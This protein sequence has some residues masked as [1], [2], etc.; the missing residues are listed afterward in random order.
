MSAQDG[1]RRRAY[2]GRVLTPV[3]AG[4]ARVPELRFLEDGVVIVGPSG[5]IESVEPA[6]PN[7][8]RPALDLHPHLI[9][10][11]FADAHVHYPQTRVVGAATGG[12]LDWLERTVF[13]EEMRFG[14]A[15]Y[16]GEVA[17]EFFG[18]LR[19]AGTTCAGIYA[20][21]SPVSAAVAM[22]RA[23]A[24]GMLAQVGLVLMDRG[25]PEGLLVPRERALADQ[26][27]LL[28]A[29]GG[30]DVRPAVTPRFALSC[31]RELLRDAGAF[32][33]ER[34]LFVQTHLSENEGEIAATRA[35]F[36]EA[37]DYFGVYEEAGLAGERSL[38]AHAIHLSPRE[39]DAV[40]GTR[41]PLVHCPDSN[42]FLGSGRMRL[43]EALRRGIRVALGSDVGAG[44]TF[45]MRRIAAAAYDTALAER[46]PVSPEEL[47][48]LATWCG[49]EALGFGD[50]AGAL[51]PGRR[52]DFAVL[53]VPA[54]ARSQHDVLG[55]A[56]FASDATPVVRT[57]LAGRLSSPSTA[58]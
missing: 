40:A 12:L 8:P 31:S 52:A 47:F 42:L 30:P 9:V 17:G 33:A 43:R 54:H 41:S 37:P 22:E 58:S 57:Y 11:G 20:T 46:D 44:R 51:T 53:D 34:R 39:W 15:A 19:A 5:L 26:A 29:H 3:P 56:L 16:A 27:A 7:A 36:P 4:G 49:A 23:E 38:F 13:P 24:I 10:P 32:A 48:S 14:D 50:R 21:S 28:A 55:H 2:R 1:A 35:A 6:S 18:K 25:A 45:D